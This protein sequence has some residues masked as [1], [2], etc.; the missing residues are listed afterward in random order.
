[1]MRFVLLLPDLQ[2]HSFFMLLA[3]PVFWSFCPEV[4]VSEALADVVP[5]SWQK[6]AGLSLDNDPKAET[7]TVTAQRIMQPVSQTGSQVTVITAKE[8]EQTQRRDLA[9]LLTYA[10]GLNMVRTAG[11]GGTGS[12]FMRGLGSN[13]V[14]VRLDGMEINDTSTP[15]GQFDTAQ[16]LTDGLGRIEI[17]RGPQ[18]GLYGADAMAGVVDMTTEKGRGPAHAWLRVEGG[19]YATANQTGRLDGEWRRFHYMVEISHTHMAHYQ[20]TPHRYRSLALDGP[21][22]I[23]TNRNDN[24]TANIRLDYEATDNLALNFTSHLTQADYKSMAYN[25]GPP[26]DYATVPSGQRNESDLNQMVLHG[27]AR[28]RSFGGVLEQMIGIGT[29][30]YRRRDATPD[31]ARIAYN[32]GDRFKADWQALLHLGRNGSFLAGYDHIREYLV[33]PERHRTSTNAI[34]GQLEGQWRDLL[35]GAVN[36][37]YD[38]NS[39]YGDYVTWRAAPSIKIPH[40]GLSLKASGGSGFHGPSLNQLFVSNTYIQANRNLRAERLQG[41]DIGFEETLR[42]GKYRFGAAYYQ[43]FVRNLI[44]YMPP[45]S[46]THG[47]GT[48]ANIAHAQTHGVEA[49][50][51]FHLVR[52]VT[53]KGNYT[54]T[55]ARDT[56]SHKTLTRRPKHKLAG[57]LFW[58]P[59]EKISIVPS[60][61]YVSSWKDV[62]DY[63]SGKVRAHDYFTFSLAAQYQILPRLQLFTRADNLADRHY[64]NPYGYLQPRRS[65]YGGMRVGL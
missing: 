54:W 47:C 39:H 5:S 1:M 42:D 31:D 7:I 48:Y 17:L 26:P 43:N 45:R 58:Q 35:S 29:V 56:D 30:N 52:N 2:K 49:F 25:Y 53:L 32:R 44:N 27:G 8:I 34:Y 4:P 40:T 23:A 60:L 51:D 3:V 65:F 19:S 18:S 55:I 28:L 38:R 62:S 13:E 64:E 22:S 6:Q 21:D 9:D 59:N 14:K 33:R 12:I 16:F 61:I 41:Y 57:S 37:R 50:A 15:N 46:G 10:P 36:I 11:P 20:Q 63:S 24:R